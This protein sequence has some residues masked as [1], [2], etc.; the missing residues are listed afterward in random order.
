MALPCVLLIGREMLSGTIKTEAEL[1][2]LISAETR[3]IGLIP[4]I[5]TQ[6]NRRR[7][8]F[9]GTSAVATSLLLCSVTGWVVWQMRAML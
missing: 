1:K 5:E 6:R 2:S 7:N 9:I 8:F 3:M 4:S